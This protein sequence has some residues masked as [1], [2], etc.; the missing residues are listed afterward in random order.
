MRANSAAVLKRD[1]ACEILL[2]SGSVQLRAQGYSMFPTVRPGDVLIVERVSLQQVKVGDVVVMSRSSGLLSHRVISIG[3]DAESALLI[4]RGD[5]SVVDDLPVRE[6]HLLGRIGYVIRKGKLIS[7]PSRLSAI[8]NVAARVFRY[9]FPAVRGVME[10]RRRW[11][12]RFR[13][14]KESIAQCQS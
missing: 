3:R 11:Q 9:S 13:T 2:S 12:K 1:M 10:M 5:T 7:V 4:T 6:S 8:D 14:P